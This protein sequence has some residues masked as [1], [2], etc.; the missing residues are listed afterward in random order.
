VTQARTSV[1][2][3]AG[4][5]EEPP[6][7]ASQGVGTGGQ[8]HVCSGLY[9]CLVRVMLYARARDARGQLQRKCSVCE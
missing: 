6:L 7:V 9:F 8:G 4:M 1:E 2:E 5:E 3:V